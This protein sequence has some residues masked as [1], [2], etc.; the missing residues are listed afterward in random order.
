MRHGASRMI[1]SMERGVKKMIGLN[2]TLLGRQH[3]YLSRRHL[4]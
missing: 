1:S 2:S 4:P 3:G